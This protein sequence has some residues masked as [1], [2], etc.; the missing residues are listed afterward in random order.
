MQRRKI[1]V[2]Y[3]FLLCKLAPDPVFDRQKAPIEHPHQQTERPEI[4]AATAV[5]LGERERLY[6]L[7]IEPAAECVRWDER[8]R[9]L[10]DQRLRQHH[11]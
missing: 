3:H 4:L 6:C 2:A 10:G 9:G 5:T 11:P 7:E 8:G 1:S